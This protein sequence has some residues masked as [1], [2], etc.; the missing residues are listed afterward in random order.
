MNFDSEPFLPSA[1]TIIAGQRCASIRPC[2]ALIIHSV[3]NK[4][5]RTACDW[6]SFASTYKDSVE[7]G[8]NQIFCISDNQAGF[9]NAFR[10]AMQKMAIIGHDRD[11]LV[12]CSDVIP[13]PKPLP[14][15]AGPHLLPDTTHGDI[16]Q[17]VRCSDSLYIS[18][19]LTSFIDDSALL[20]R[21]LFLLLFR[22]SGKFCCRIDCYVLITMLSQDPLHLLLQCML[23][24]W[25]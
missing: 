25:T 12:D 9:Q 1:F 17:A 13:V 7:G 15:S 21:S 23:I 11:A 22:V 19:K 8:Q 16:E 5:S 18:I 2:T 14:A 4:D 6:Q 3:K 10:A 24:L 20:L